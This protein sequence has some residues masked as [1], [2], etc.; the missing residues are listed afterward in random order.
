MV[1]CYTPNRTKTNNLESPFNIKTRTLPTPV[2]LFLYSFG[3]IPLLLLEK[4]TILNF[5]FNIP[6]YFYI[7]SSCV[8]VSLSNHSVRRL[9]LSFIMFLWFNCNVESTAHIIFQYNI[10]PLIPI[11]YC[12]S[13]FSFFFMPNVIWRTRAGKNISQLMSV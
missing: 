6:L 1:L 4:I 7:V 8:Y 2:N 5:A 11:L 3:Y 9:D 13:L 12:Y 10:K